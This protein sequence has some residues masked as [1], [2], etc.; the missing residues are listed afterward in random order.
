MSVDEP[1][2]W[3]TG[4][5][6]LCLNE[7]GCNNFCKNNVRRCREYCQSHAENPL[8]QK[9]FS[10][11][12]QPSPSAEEEKKDIAA[13][14]IATKESI[15]VPKSE[16]RPARKD[17]TGTGSVAFTSP[18]MRLH[19]IREIVPMGLLNG[20]HVTPT[21][22]GYYH[23]VSVDRLNPDDPS[24]YRDI[25][26]PADGIIADIN[27]MGGKQND[28]RMTL[29]YTCTFYT[30]YI[31]LS[32]LSQKI[33][34]ATGGVKGFMPTSIPVKAG[35]II[36]RAQ[37][38]DFSVHNEEVV[39]KGFVI[40]EHYE[41]ESWKIHTVDMFD[42]F[43][44][45]IKSKLL[46]KNIRQAHP[47]GG[48]IDY[49]IDG[50]L[51]GNWFVEGTGG[52]RGVQGD[53]WVT[54]LA[55][56]YDALDPSLAVVSIGDFRG[57][58]KHFAIKGNTPDPAIVSVASGLVKYELTGIEYLTESGQIW[59]RNEFAKISKAIESGPIIDEVERVEGVVL[60]QMLGERKL[61]FEAFPGKTASE[62]VGF[63]DAATLYER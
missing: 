25:L 39:L 24:T 49:D 60:A 12:L 6:D 21:D 58:P 23:S 52:Y 32:E 41:G 37:G 18:P 43:V 51:V 50:K 40:P 9:P 11:E 7:E 8:C 59:N 35:E 15:I 55:F 2:A 13:E 20:S 14:G 45:P 57:M 44:E 42:S 31:H 26:A 10:L 47:R 34:Q 5:G 1:I 53:Y 3:G 62:I 46:S 29:N 22:H 63:T 54:H 56:A 36:G 27:I 17:C 19:E 16:K 48:K 4:L 33:L 38:F 28:Y 30:I 61:K